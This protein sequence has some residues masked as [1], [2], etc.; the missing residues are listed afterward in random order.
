MYKSDE[1]EIKV[2]TRKTRHLKQNQ[3]KAERRIRK[4]KRVLIGDK[5]RDSKGIYESGLKALIH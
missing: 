2:F 3:A 5:T 4:Y 1:T